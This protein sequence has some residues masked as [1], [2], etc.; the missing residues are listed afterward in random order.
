LVVN[1][2]AST[3]PTSPLTVSPHHRRVASF[4]RVQPLSS[5]LSFMSSP[6]VFPVAASVACAA[7]LHAILLPPP[8]YVALL[9][10]AS[11]FVHF[12]TA[13]RP[14]SLICCA[15]T[16][17]ALSAVGSAGFSHALQASDSAN[18]GLFVAL[19][20]IYHCGE[21]FAIALSKPA[22]VDNF[23]KLVLC[24]VRLMLL[25]TS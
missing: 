23:G 1:L 10:F 7:L 17:F 9:C 19:V 2:Q 24:V 20:A 13:S 22:N 4:Q 6:L 8:V 3:D 12:A 18:F 11:V 21:F 5:K 15:N 25:L 14:D 16:A